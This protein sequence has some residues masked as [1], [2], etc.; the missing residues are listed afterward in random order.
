MSSASDPRWRTIEKCTPILEETFRPRGVIRVRWVASFPTNGSASA[1]LC[2][3]TDAERDAMRTDPH[4]GD[5]VRE[6]LLAQGFPARDA[7]KSGAWIES[8][9]TVDRD[10]D[11]SWFHAMR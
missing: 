4:V 9:E 5:G 8:Q 2:V 7:A 6:T 3:T 10:F 11:S 1:W